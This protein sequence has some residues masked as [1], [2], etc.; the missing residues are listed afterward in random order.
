[1]LRPGPVHSAKQSLAIRR[2]FGEAV[3]GRIEALSR[4]RAL[5]SEK[6]LLLQKE[7]TCFLVAICCYLLVEICSMRC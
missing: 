1:M 2:T 4:P 3:T 6:Q 5:V 7:G